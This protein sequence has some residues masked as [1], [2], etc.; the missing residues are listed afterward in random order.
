MT[1]H[2]HKTKKLDSF[3]INGQ[4]DMT[5]SK[6]LLLF[7]TLLVKKMTYSKLI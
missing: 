3:S 6:K 1:K 4:V 5:E 2:I 7:Q